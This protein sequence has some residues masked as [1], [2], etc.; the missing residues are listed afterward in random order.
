MRYTSIL[1]VVVALLVLLGVTGS[2][3]GAQEGAPGDFCSYSPDR[4]L[5]WHFSPACEQH[6][7]CLD[8]L[9]TSV[10][11]EDRLRCDDEFQGHL[12]V[13]TRD[14]TPGVCAD[15]AVCRFIADIYYLVVRFLTVQ[16]YA[17]LG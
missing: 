13:T 4:P 11:L 1:P 7:G 2:P 5:R 15:N 6:D 16:N 9:P 12:Y 3:A 10:T 14:G 8:A 17:Q